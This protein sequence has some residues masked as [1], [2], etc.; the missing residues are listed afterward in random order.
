MFVGGVA[1]WLAY[2]VWKGAPSVIA[3]NAVTLVLAGYIL[4]VKL[5]RAPQATPPAR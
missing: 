2:G 4:R 5:R 1:L 3:A